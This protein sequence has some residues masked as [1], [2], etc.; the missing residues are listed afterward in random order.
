MYASAAGTLGAACSH[1]CDT[2]RPVHGGGCREGSGRPAG[3]RTCWAAPPALHAT[4]IAPNHSSSTPSAQRLTKRVA[5][6]D[7]CCAH[8]AVAQCGAGE[9]GLGAHHRHAL[10]R[11]LALAARRPCCCRRHSL[12]H[13]LP[14]PPLS[15]ALLLEVLPPLLLR[16]PQ[17]KGAQLLPPPAVASSALITQVRRLHC[18]YGVR[19]AVG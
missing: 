7:A 6:H 19:W 8:A 4:Q 1:C 15:A 18:V 5:D 3:C 14:P 17:R 9:E 13:R 11:S 2:P 12:A 16:T 10:G